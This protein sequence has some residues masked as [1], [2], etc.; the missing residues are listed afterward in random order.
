MKPEQALKIIDGIEE[1]RGTLPEDGNLVDEALIDAKAA[2]QKQIPKN[3]IWSYAYSEWFRE[4]LKHVEKGTL[5]NT[6]T[7]CCPICKC[8]LITSVLAKAA[9]D[10]V[11]GDQYCK[12]CGQHISWDNVP[13]KMEEKE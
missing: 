3:P 6:K 13:E 1:V 11:Y 12:H 10:K 7:Y 4:K 9:K 8:S 5:A 2:L